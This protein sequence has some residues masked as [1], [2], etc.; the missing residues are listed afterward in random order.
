MLPSWVIVLKLSKNV[1]LL[2]F[3]ADLS[4]KP[5]SVK[6]IYLY[7]SESSYYT[8]SENDMVYMGLS[9]SWRDNCN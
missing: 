6:V 9:Y 1:Q 2:Q 5:N 8:L 4:K 3:C 7:A